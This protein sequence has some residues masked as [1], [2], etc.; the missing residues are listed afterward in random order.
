PLYELQQ[1]VEDKILA[2]VRGVYGGEGVEYSPK[3]R[4]ML[5]QIHDNGWSHLPVCIAK[6]QYSFSDDPQLLGAARGF[7]VQVRELIPKTG[8][9][10]IVAITGA[11]TTMPGLPRVPAAMHMDVDEHGN[12]IGLS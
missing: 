2:L 7:T 9:G 12:A 11:L 1:P 3:A 10:F 4:R 5:Q 8:A 6:T